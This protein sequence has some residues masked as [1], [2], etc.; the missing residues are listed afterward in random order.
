[1]GQFVGGHKHGKGAETSAADPAGNRE[2]Y[3]GDWD[4]GRKHGRGVHHFADG[5]YSP[6][7]SFTT[8]PTAGAARHP[9]PSPRAVTRIIT[10]TLTVT[11]TLTAQ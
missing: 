9:E 2:K 6:P 11:A 10:R 7:H 3:D 4:S 1:M 5:R 8:S